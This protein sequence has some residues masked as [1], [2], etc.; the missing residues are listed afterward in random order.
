MVGCI[1]NRESLFF[2]PLQTVLNKFYHETFMV[3]FGFAGF[4][5]LRKLLRDETVTADALSDWFSLLG[6]LKLLYR[7]FRAIFHCQYYFKLPAG[8]Y[9]MKVYKKTIIANANGNC[10]SGRTRRFIICARYT[11]N[12]YTYGHLVI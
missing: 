4:Y 9:K 8:P 3:A 2:N 10:S 6:P 11:M 12:F 5:N 7:P 1:C